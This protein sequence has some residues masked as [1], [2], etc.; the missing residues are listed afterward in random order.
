MR[1]RQVSKK[2]NLLRATCSEILF[3]ALYE[4]E[5]ETNEVVSRAAS[6]DLT[7]PGMQRARG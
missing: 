2:H 1:P 7:I 5:A 3:V 6:R 4:T